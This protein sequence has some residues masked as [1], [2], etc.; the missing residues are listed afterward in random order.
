MIVFESV[1][2]IE[3]V[4]VSELD[5]RCTKYFYLYGDAA[6]MLPYGQKFSCN[7]VITTN[8]PFMV[9]TL[10]YFTINQKYVK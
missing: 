10:P 5:N 6:A 1:A 9:T 7:M 8:R 4:L 2:M 3:I